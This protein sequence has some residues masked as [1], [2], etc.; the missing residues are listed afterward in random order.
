MSLGLTLY[1][2]ATT[3]AEPLAGP[4]LRGRAR[5][6]K[7]DA[8]RLGETDDGAL[9]QCQPAPPQLLRRNAQLA[10]Q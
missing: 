4:V 5:R 3:L 2:A 10:A 7:E 1:R 6:G 9:G 8:A